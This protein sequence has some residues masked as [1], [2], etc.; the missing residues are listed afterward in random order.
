MRTGAPV[1]ITFE[2]TTTFDSCGTGVESF[3]RVVF[4][5]PATFDR[6]ITG[7]DAGGPVVF[8]GPA[9][10]TRCTGPTG[11]ALLAELGAVV[12]FNGPVCLQNN[13]DT[14][15]YAAVVVDDSATVSF[16]G[17]QQT[18]SGN[19]PANVAVV[20]AN[21]TLTC[22][23]RAKAPGRYTTPAGGPIC[24]GCPNATT[25]VANATTPVTDCAGCPTGYYTP[26]ACACVVRPD[27]RGAAFCC[28]GPLEA[29]LTT[30]CLPRARASELHDRPVLWA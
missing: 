15:G 29:V 8:N 24:S 14:A 26:A 18:A 22:N 17:N 5:G 20:D 6:C 27:G 7:V 19:V 16:N 12:S 9:A 28:T 30:C 1:N 13:N 4:S 10:F 2:G 25:G 11:P 21:A 23:G 3:G